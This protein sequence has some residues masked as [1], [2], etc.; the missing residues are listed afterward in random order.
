[1]LLCVLLF[2]AAHDARQNMAVTVEHIGSAKEEFDR[3]YGYKQVDK[4][5]LLIN[6]PLGEYQYQDTLHVGSFLLILYS[7]MVFCA[8]PI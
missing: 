7:A 2:Q 3:R 8:M 5:D 6:S 1:M 4:H